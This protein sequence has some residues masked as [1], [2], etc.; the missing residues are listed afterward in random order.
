MPSLSVRK[1]TRQYDLDLIIASNAGIS[2]GDMVWDAVGIIPPRFGRRGAPSNV[3]NALELIGQIDQ[4]QREALQRKAR[5]LPL[6][7]G[8]L[9]GI[10]VHLDAEHSGDFKYPAMVAVASKIAVEKISAFNF[11]DIGVRRMSHGMRMTT[12]RALNEVKRSQWAKYDI[13]VRRSFIITE[14]YYGSVTVSLDT[15]VAVAAD[16]QILTDQGFKLIASDTVNRTEVYRMDVADV[17]FAMR[18]ELARRFTA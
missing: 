1:F 5:D 4:E 15:K 8:A 9:A 11:G 17:P 2:V 6:E 3:F 18:T 13:T 7:A 16:L 12:D 10:E 14:L